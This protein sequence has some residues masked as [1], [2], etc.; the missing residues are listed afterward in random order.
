MG[1][2][3]ASASIVAA[4]AALAQQASPNQLQGAYQTPAEAAPA[5]APAST[6]APPARP[7]RKDRRVGKLHDKLRGQEK[8][9]ERDR[10]EAA[11]PSDP[12]AG[13]LSFKKD[14]KDATGVTFQ[15]QPG[16]MGQ[17]GAPNAGPNAGQ[18]MWT[19][20]LNWDMFDSDAIGQGSL[21]IGYTYN[22]YW[23]RQSGATMSTRLNILSQI[24][25]SAA[26]TYN[27]STLTYTHVFP[28]NLVQATVG[29]FGF[30][31]FDSNQYAGNQMTNFVNYALSQN[32]SQSYIPD[33]LGGYVQL[34]PTSEI[35]IAAGGQNAENVSGDTIQTNQTFNGPWAWF[36]YGQWT[37]TL[38]FLP[39][40]Q[41][42]QYS[43][44][45]Y[46]QPSVPLQPYSS[47]GWSVNAV[48]NLNG[49]WGLFARA[50]HSTG[51]IS[52]IATS[53]AG[54]VV[55]NGPFG[56]TKDQVGVGLAVNYVNESA[57][58]GQ[59]VRASETV[60]EAYYNHVFFKWMQMG[61]DVQVIFN[62]ALSPQAPTAE[63]FTFRITGLI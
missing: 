21:Q 61:P 42:S 25:D 22:N 44:L 49:T 18:F 53:V 30:S 12:Y 24:N 15:L 19:P 10:E 13:F 63:V 5:A 11:A 26:N 38:P 41:S 14:L 23:T 33:S 36:V 32:G 6:G 7:H 45:I 28:G 59:P 16:V 47:T 48:Q 8:A 57:F 17:W 37:P 52:P 58:V 54:G 20:S 3:L 50:N 55:Y 56:F 29:Q 34:N 9:D 62:P 4:G 39:S 43:L 60:A 1:W 35:S 51:E 31:N 2:M 40:G 27:F 46:N